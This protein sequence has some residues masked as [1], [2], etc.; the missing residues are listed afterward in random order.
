MGTQEM[1]PASEFFDI[2]VSVSVSR[3]LSLLRQSFDMDIAFIGKFENGSRTTV[4]V[5]GKEGVELPKTGSFCHADEDTYCKKIAEGELP[6]IISDTS[7]NPITRKMPIT[8]E[9]SIG[10]YIGVPLYLSGGELYGTLCCMKRSSDRSLEQRDPA[11]LRFVASV[12]ADRIEAY[13]NAQLRTKEIRQRLS[14]LLSKQQLEMY[15]QPIWSVASA[16]IAGY[17]ALARFKTEPYRTPDVWFGEAAEVGQREILE[18]MAIKLALD[19]LSR[20][21]EPCFLSVNASPE[22]ILSGEAERLINRFAAHRIILEIT[23]HSRIVNYSELREAAHNLRQMGVRLAIDDAGAGYATFQHVLELDV[24]VIKLD[25]TLIRDIHIDEKKQ[26]L[27]AA[28][29]SYARRARAK[30][31]AEG[32]ETQEEFNMLRELNVDKIQGYLIGKPAPLSTALEGQ[33]L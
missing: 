25:L 27:A 5:D 3:L 24:D 10:S 33:M 11:I 22:L 6:A 31:V 8:D 12:I 2:D 19:Q 7:R 13:R 4:F 29:V 21:P 14:D 23:E 26:A 32:V 18:S 17:E 1:V 20:L 28:L 30:V 15:F 16:S 9:L